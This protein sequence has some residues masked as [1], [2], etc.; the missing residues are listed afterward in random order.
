MARRPASTTSKKPPY[1]HGD[2]RNALEEAALVLIRKHGPNAVSLREVAKQAGVSHAAPY[3]HFEDKHALLAAIAHEGFRRLGQAMA[4]VEARHADPRV[5]LI[6]AG[7]A[8]TELALKNPEI[9]QLM[10]GGYLDPGRCGEELRA[11]ADK[12]FQGLVKIIENGKAA[13]LLKKRDSQEL[14]LA[15]WSMA[16]GYSMLAIGGQLAEVAPRK[17]DIDV[18][19]RALCRLLLDGLAA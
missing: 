15:A 14:A 12:A 4:D 10:F 13:G 1:H 11:D 17:K 19:N 18:L 5:Q 3:R 6:E 7:R 2:L 9:V 16:H 8:Y